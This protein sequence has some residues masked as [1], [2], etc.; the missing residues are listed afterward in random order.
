LLA[1]NGCHAELMRE[2][3]NFFLHAPFNLQLQKILASIQRDFFARL[4]ARTI[5]LILLAPF[6]QKAG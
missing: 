3:C 6:G 1:G 5:N 2:P 4:I